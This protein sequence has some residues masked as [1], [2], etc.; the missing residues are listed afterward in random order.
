M[1]DPQAKLV[2][3][4][5]Q[6]EED[7]Q[8]RQRVVGNEAEEHREDDNRFKHAR[9]QELKRRHG[10]GD[11]ATVLGHLYVRLYMRASVRCLLRGRVRVNV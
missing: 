11:L 5:Q 1:S 3:Q 8:G 2:L 9:P 10:V 7:T 4:R 6:Q